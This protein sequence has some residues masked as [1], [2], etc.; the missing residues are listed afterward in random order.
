MTPDLATT[1]AF[2]GI[3][4][5][6]SAVEA[7]VLVALFAGG[8]VLYR[9]LMRTV[10]DIEAKHVAPA[11]ARLN[12]ILDDLKGVT[13]VMRGAADGAD[14]AVRSGLAWFLRRFRS[15]RRDA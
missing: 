1:N 10:V 3:M 2:L 13:W 9:R 5:A 15:D 8:I 4:A 11:S 6:V 14:S 12:A 7:L